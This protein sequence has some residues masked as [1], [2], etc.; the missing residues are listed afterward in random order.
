MKKVIIGF[1]IFFIVLVAAAIL[2]PILFKDKIKQAVDKQIAQNIHATVIYETDDISLSLFRDFPDVSLGI[3]NLTVVGQ[4]SFQTDTL[5]IIPSFRLGLNLMSVISGDELKVNKVVLQEPKIRLVVLESGKANWDIFISDTTAAPA[6]T[7]ASDFKMAIKGWNINNGTLY[8]DDLSIPFGLAMYG[9]NHS[10]SGDFEQSVFDMDSK[11]TAE[12][13]TMTYDGVNYIQNATLNADVTLEMNLEKALYTFKNNNISVNE[14]PFQFAGSILMPADDIDLDLTFKATETDFRNVL[15]VVPGM[16]TEDFKNIK[17]EGKLSFDGYLKG[18]L[19][20]SLMPG[21]GTDLKIAE[22]YFKYP[23]LPQAARNINVDMSIDNKD[24]N[25]DNTNILVRQ[26][27]LDLG[28]NPVDAKVSVQGLETMLVDGNVKASID[29]DEITKVF[30]VD[31]MTLRGLLK[32]DATA[33]GTYSET[34]MPVVNADMRLTNGYVKSKDFPAPIQNLNVVANILNTTGNTDDTR[35][36]IQ[37]FNMNL[38]GEPLEGR[39]LVQGIDKPAFDANIKG[40]L[41]LTK[42][43][44]IFPLEDMTVS[45]RINANVAAKGKMSDIE[46]EKY[47]NVTANGS[48][49][50]SNLEFVSKDMPQGI[51]INSANAVFNNERIDLQNM[52]GYLGKSDIQASGS[53]S[54]YLGYALADDQ[55]LRGTFNLAS[56]KFN[57]NEWMVDENTGQPVPETEA[58]VVEVPGNLDITLNIDAKQVVY[59]NLNLSNMSG[60][61]LV[62]DKVARLQQVS[63]NTLGGSFVTSGSYNTQNLQKPLFDFNLDIKNLKFKEAFNA[64]NTIKAVA[65]IAGLLEGTFSTKFNFAGELGQDMMPIFSTLDGAGVIEVIKAAV[66]DVK[67]VDKISSLTNFEEL[68]NFVVENK[69]IDAQIVDGSLVVKPFDLKIGNVDMTVGGSNNVNGN[70]DYVTALNVPTGKVGQQLNSRLTSLIGSDVKA[71]ER[72]TLNLNIGGTLTD[73]RVSLAGGSAKGQAKEAVQNLVQNKL[74]DAKAQVEQR[75]QQAQDSLTNELN[76]RKLEAEQ[77]AREE[78]EKKRL[79]AE[80]KAKDQISNKLNSLL[81]PKTTTQPADTAGN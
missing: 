65:P 74:D 70:I 75:K 42:L 18:R 5:A 43:T 72:V 25:L 20:D 23:D 3:D 59:D 37:N 76:R 60:K 69:K 26:F 58:G 33:K 77:K 78:L 10:G 67:I 54:N 44:K 17:T 8:Y 32:V 9:I 62:K 80:K 51:K 14:F 15:S 2:V 4:D 30:P 36:N 55:S 52:S 47:N 21:F 28:K 7:A 61:V 41:D 53:I 16:Y 68:K 35:I 38:D 64:F 46:A 45:G 56:N 24:G 34:K 19:N 12:R 57:V 29:L 66:R 73:P 48:M 63:F 22:G 49:A 50:I 6:D 40:I 11:T 27:H 1:A 31:G 71:A 13:F 79:E 81:K 39:V